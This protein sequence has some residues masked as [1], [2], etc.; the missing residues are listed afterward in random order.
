[1]ATGIS[2]LII[3]ALF[4]HF[5]GLDFRNTAKTIDRCCTYTD[6]LHFRL[7]T[8]VTHCCLVLVRMVDVINLCRNISDGVRPYPLNRY[9]D[10]DILS[11]EGMN[12][13]TS[14]STNRDQRMS[15]HLQSSTSGT[16]I[17]IIIHKSEEQT[18]I[19]KSSRDCYS[20]F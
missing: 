7:P 5:L 19:I 18:R 14:L 11:H 10:P 9:F 6:R 17:P 13:L 20:Y 12:S 15:N 8:W 16:N 3:Y 2:E 4:I 1:M